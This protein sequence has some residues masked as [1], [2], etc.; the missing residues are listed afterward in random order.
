VGK[1]DNVNYIP[2]EPIVIWESELRKATIPLREFYSIWQEIKADIF[3]LENVVAMK[4][5]VLVEVKESTV[6]IRKNDV[7]NNEKFLL[8]FNCPSQSEI[9]VK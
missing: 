1:F 8:Q 5:N 4:K 2:D 9:I 7:N 3:S 6:F